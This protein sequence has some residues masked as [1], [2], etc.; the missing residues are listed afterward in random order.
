MEGMCLWKCQRCQS[1]YP[2][3][4]WLIINRPS[5]LVFHY[6]PLIVELFL[7]HCRKEVSHPICLEPQ[8][9]R[10]LVRRNCFVVVRP[11][12]PG[13]SIESST[14]SLNQLEMLIRAHV[15][16]TLKQHMLEQMRK[17]GAAGLLICRPD[18]IPEVDRNDRRGVIFR[19]RNEQPVV[20]A[21]CVDRY[22]H[23]IK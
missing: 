8:R 22:S 3:S 9:E 2:G 15:L 11:L 14:C 5:T 6:I 23:A 12:E 7:G 13:R 19:E 17:S 1:L 16:G 21:K 20:Q 10:Q 4:I 18:V